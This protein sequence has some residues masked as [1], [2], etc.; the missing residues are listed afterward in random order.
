M[1]AF[2]RRIVAWF[3]PV[4]DSVSGHLNVEELVRVVVVALAATGTVTGIKA[5]VTGHLSTILAPADLPLGTALF[6]LIFETLRRLAHG[7]EMH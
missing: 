1:R 4:R 2:L 3:G 5:E 6:A 7:R